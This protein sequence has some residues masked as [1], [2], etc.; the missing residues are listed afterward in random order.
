MIR[1]TTST[2]KP[3]L[4]KGSD[5]LGLIGVYTNVPNILK[6]LIDFNNQQ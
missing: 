5:D 6:I 4:M 1:K 3:T 2:N